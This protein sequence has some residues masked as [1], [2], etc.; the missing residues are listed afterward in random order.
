M[1]IRELNGRF[2][3]WGLTLLVV[4]DREPWLNAAVLFIHFDNTFNQ[5]T[6]GGVCCHYQSSFIAAGGSDIITNARRPFAFCGDALVTCIKAR[7]YFFFLGLQTVG[8]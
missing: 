2:L 5:V 7:R 4:Y 1:P 6:S 3:L 8:F